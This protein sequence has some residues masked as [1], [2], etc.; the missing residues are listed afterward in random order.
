[1]SMPVDRVVDSASGLTESRLLQHYQAVAEL[2]MPHLQARPVAFLRAPEGIEAGMFFQKHLP[3]PALPGIAQFSSSLYASHGP[4][5]EVREPRG[6]LSAVHAHVI[7]FHTFNTTTRGNEHPDRVCFD[8]DPGEGVEWNSVREAALHLRDVLAQLGLSC[9]L[10][11]SGGKGLH[12]LVP[13]APALHSCE[14]AKHFAKALVQR[15]AQEEPSRFSAMS[16]PRNRIGRIFIDYLRNGAGATTVCAWS[17][18]AR[19]GLPVSVPIAWSELP[20]LQSS[21]QWNIANCAERNELGN[22]PWEGYWQCRQNLHQALQ[23]LPAADE[24][25]K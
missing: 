15:L 14:T 4:L 5:L 18:R 7:E 11:T 21:A 2:M 17:A 22:Q 10:K 16:G 19:P 25:L 13:L 12:L 3:S 24:H 6:V 8:L 20:G 1:M 9:W 23:Q